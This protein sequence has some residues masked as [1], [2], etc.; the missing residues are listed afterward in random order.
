M[1]VVASLAGGAAYLMPSKKISD[2][3]ELLNQRLDKIEKAIYT[4]FLD[5][6]RLPCPATRTNLIGSAS[7]GVPTDCSAAA[8]S[9]VTDITP[10]TVTTSIRN[11]VVPVR[12][13]NLPDSYMF[14]PWG[15]RINYSVIKK[16]AIDNATF[17][18]LESVITEDI[19]KIRDES[20]NQLNLLY[21]ATN[22]I[23]LT[24]VLYSNGKNR[25]G[26]TNSS[27]VTATCASGALDYENCNGDNIF[28]YTNHNYT[29]GATYN[30]DVIRW[31]TNRDLYNC[32]GATK[33][34]AC[35]I[36]PVGF[37]PNDIYGLITWID[38]NDTSMFTWY[39]NTTDI[40]HWMTEKSAETDW[41]DCD[42]NDPNIMPQWLPTGFNGK[43]TLN[44][45]G[46][47]GIFYCPD[48]PTPQSGT[49]IFNYTIFFV[50]QV[51]TPAAT[52]YFL[53]SYTYASNLILNL[54]NTNGNN[55]WYTH[56]GNT[57]T[58][59]TSYTGNMYASFIF[60][61][62]APTP[63]VKAYINGTQVLTANTYSG[64]KHNTFFQ[65]ICIGRNYAGPASTD[66]DGKLSEF[67]I[68]KR[69]LTD[70]E[71]QYVENY[72][73]AKWGL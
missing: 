31:Y 33:A 59:S 26:G 57:G 66:F 36:P 52:N 20:N 69:A 32:A 54:N 44:M 60:D 4:Y 10:G 11:G 2:D 42:P 22:K 47:T 49:D 64:F 70:S 63:Q 55:T 56:K 40:V 24:H 51:N 14:D 27:G 62:T 28:R 30:D 65:N 45:T 48:N 41:Y 12:A 39:T 6:G 37:T 1:L 13:L 58:L 61:I 19:I 35:N 16:A 17:T 29:D 23:F 15:N 71:R 53:T 38:A 9:G 73:K 72:L 67:L 25:N 7:F 18:D 46:K 5:K 50:G 3:I 34:S 68:Y 43:P 8:P 21:S